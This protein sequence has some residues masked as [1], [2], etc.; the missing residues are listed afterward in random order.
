[1]KKNFTV[2]VCPNAFKESLSAVAA[3]KVIHRGIHRVWANAKVLELPVAD[4]GNGTLDVLV[5]GQAGK[6]K[7]VRVTGPL[8]IPVTARLGIVAD[9]H[10]AVIEMAEASGLHL[11]LPAK[12][13]PLI[14]TTYG[15]GELIRHALDWGAKEIIIGVGGS[16]T[17]DGGVG[18]AMALGAKF[19]DKKGKPVGFGGKE[20]N[21]IHRVDLSSLDARIQK[22]KINIACDVQNPLLGPN[23][24]VAV[25]ARQKGATARMLPILESGLRNVFL[26][27]SFR[28]PHS[29]LGKGSGAAGGLAAGLVAFCGAQIQ[30]GADLILDTLYFDNYLR[31]A[32]LVITGEGKLDE[33]TVH[34]K[35]PIAV[36]L[37]AKKR[38]IP[39][40]AIA[41]SL[42]ENADRLHQFGITYMKSI[43]SRPM[44][45][46]ESMQ[47]TEKLIQQSI[48]EITHLIMRF[49]IGNS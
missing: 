21:R 39:V 30:S 9:K 32:D 26:N 42:G 11:V 5:S 35:A 1:M 25:Y 47:N 15:T 23:G 2:L 24:S 6:I 19:L 3:A 18:M 28:I 22:T 4:G 37:R 13:N 10:L 41:G 40:I 31:Q 8:G 20:L 48:E 29:A 45:L 49:C 44:S 16:A 34:G 14:T 36:A 33:Q 12:R 7:K 27:S 46:Q 43:Q 17:V 38:G